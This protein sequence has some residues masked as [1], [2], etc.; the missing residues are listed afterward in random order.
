MKAEKNKLIKVNLEQI[1]YAG[2]VTLIIAMPFHAFLTIYFG[3]LLHLGHRLQAWK[4]ILTVAL[5]AI[6]A[7]Y[8]F[9]KKEARLKLDQLNKLVIAI[10]ILALVVSLVRFGSLSALIFGIKTDLMPL[11]IFLLAQIVASRFD[12]FKVYNLIVWPAFIVSVL[13]ILQALA[14]PP[15]FLTKLGYGSSTIIPGQYVDST[16]MVIRAFSTLGGPNQLGAYLILPITLVTANLVKK[17]DGKKL[18][19]LLSLL[20]GLYLTYSRSAW[21]GAALAILTTIIVSVSKKSRVKILIG[22]GIVTGLGLLLIVSRNFCDPSNTIQYYLLHG[23]C[24]NNSLKGS[25]Q[26]RLSSLKAG[27]EDALKNPLGK[28]LGTAGPASYHSLKSLITENWY[29][30]IAIELGLIGLI[31]FIAFF[32]INAF[33]LFKD[34][35]DSKNLASIGLFASIIGLAG[36]NMFLHSFSDSTLAITLLALLGVQHGRRQ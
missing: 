19:I 33:S 12:E 1:L 18:I 3:N 13:A 10:F 6:A 9:N 15:D 2:I 26:I 36:T 7:V 25:D 21:I 22:L 30:Q 23:S 20:T 35:L 16:T 14:I 5:A 27:L 11:V 28:G 24:T 4:E 31:L 32:V 29:L 34:S 17:F 8:L